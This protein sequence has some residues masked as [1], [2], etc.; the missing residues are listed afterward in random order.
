MNLLYKK[1]LEVPSDTESLKKKLEKLLKHKFNNKSK[2]HKSKKHKSNN[3][4]KKH[5]S[6]KHKSKKH[7][8]KKQ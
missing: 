6:K 3:K 7:K 2:K 4:S 8:S 1:I 5:K